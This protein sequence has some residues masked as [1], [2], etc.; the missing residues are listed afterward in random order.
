MPG[1]PLSG[2]I[3]TRKSRTGNVVIA[4][5]AVAA[6]LWIAAPRN[7]SGEEKKVKTDLHKKMEVIDNGMKKLRR[8]LRKKENNPES[9]ELIT[10]I[11]E[12]A[13]ACKQMTPSRTTTMPADQQP[14]FLVTYRKEMAKLV[15][16]MVQMETALLDGDNASAQEVFKKLKD[17]EEDGH[18]KFMQS[19]DKDSAAKDDD[20]K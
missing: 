7:T 15:G 13:I 3:S 10:S 19:D 2:M 14:A 18:D 11:E 12:A 9:L 5:C 4:L 20:K 8:T 16:E 1:D 6:I 17:T